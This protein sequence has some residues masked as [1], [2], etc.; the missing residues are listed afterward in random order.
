MLYK[1]SSSLHLSVTG[2]KSMMSFAVHMTNHFSGLLQPFFIHLNLLG[3]MCYVYAI[4]VIHIFHGNRCWVSHPAVLA[5]IASF[6]TVSLLLLL[7]LLSV[8]I[9][10]LIILARIHKGNVN[11]PLKGLYSYAFLFKLQRYSFHLS[12]VWCETEDWKRYMYCWVIYKGTNLQLKVPAS[13]C[14]AINLT[15]QSWSS[16]NVPT[17][18][19]LV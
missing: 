1:T 18:C 19:S 7:L 8:L 2:D 14:Q 11:S 15:R 17:C 16:A 4:N 9:V 5:R 10:F 13:F 6:L 12:D 3:L